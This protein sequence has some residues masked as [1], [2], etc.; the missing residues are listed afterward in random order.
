[1]TKTN[2][3]AD[4]IQSRY[5]LALCLLA[6]VVV[7]SLCVGAKSI[8]LAVVYDSLFGS[9]QHPDSIIVLQSRLPRTIL[10]L[11][12]GAALGLAGA[13]IQ[14]LTRNPLADPGLLGVNAGASFAVVLAVAVFQIHQPLAYMGFACA[15]ALLT[16][17]LVYFVGIWG[18]ARLDPSRFIL[19]GVAMGAVMGGISSGLVLFNP[20]AF[21]HVRFWSAGSLDVRNL[22]LVLLGL[23][24]I[25]T[26]SILA[27]L[28]A[29]PL[30]AL[31]MG[32][33][34]AVT[35]GTRPLLTQT[36]SIIAITLLTGATTAVAGPIGFVG[37]MI[38]QLARWMAGPDQRRVL[39]LTLLLAPV[40]LL[41][42]DIIGRLL[43]PA[44][45][46]VSIV[47]AF[48]G[49]PMLIWLARRQGRRA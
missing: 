43:L 46:R 40:L 39:P 17:L 8:P 25:I 28:L 9:T 32:A 37:L 18:S 13:L 47:T 16:T 35:L 2:L 36:L 15:G 31:S 14:A 33:E 41:S 12:A 26:G 11:S 44:E 34:L 29:R 48:V 21:D 45:L 42:A 4:S 5:L 22:H 6:V 27:L 30:N 23:P 20:G 49:A 7:L 38:P 19:A 24:A 1:M 3:P 10:G